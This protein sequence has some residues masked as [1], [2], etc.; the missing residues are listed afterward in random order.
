RK[1]SCHSTAASAAVEWQLFFLM[2]ARRRRDGDHLERGLKNSGRPM[3]R[4]YL[5]LTLMRYNKEKYVW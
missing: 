4:S 5:Y 1:N 3:L 2:S